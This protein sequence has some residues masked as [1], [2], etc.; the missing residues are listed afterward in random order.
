[1]FCITDLGFLRD[2]AHALFVCSPAILAVGII[3]IEE[4]K[5]RKE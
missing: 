2:L 3:Y 1:M 5:E 4:N